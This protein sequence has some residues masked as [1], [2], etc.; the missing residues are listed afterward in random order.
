MIS[1]EWSMIPGVYE[2][3]VII[4]AGALAYELFIGPFHPLP[5]RISKLNTA[6]QLLYVFFVISYASF[7]WPPR[8]SIL[9]IGAGVCFASLVS[10]IDYV[11]RWS[12]LVLAAVRK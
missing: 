6:F 4:I 9:V 5:S 3:H 2:K 12:S 11:L 8:I 10:G 7:A 1:R